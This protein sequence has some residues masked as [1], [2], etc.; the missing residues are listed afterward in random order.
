MKGENFPV[1]HGV[2]T[3]EAEAEAKYPGEHSVQCVF[4]PTEDCEKEPEW[5]SLQKVEPAEE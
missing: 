5:H 4:I 1:G 3:L 2:Q